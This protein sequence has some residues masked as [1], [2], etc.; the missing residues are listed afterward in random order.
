MVPKDFQ[1]LLCE[2]KK[3]DGQLDKSRDE[4]SNV[5]RYNLKMDSPVVINLI[6]KSCEILSKSTRTN[7]DINILM[8]KTRNL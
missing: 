2:L 1:K 5:I 6:K 3:Y 4:T 8:P 7:K